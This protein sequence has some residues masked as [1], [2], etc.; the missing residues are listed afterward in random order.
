MLSII[1]FIAFKR[2][3]DGI[4]G[5]VFMFVCC[6]YALWK[7]SIW[8]WVTL[9]MFQFVSTQVLLCIFVMR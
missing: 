1:M 4:V 7:Q 6:V 3:D 5:I 2:L 8:T 9:E